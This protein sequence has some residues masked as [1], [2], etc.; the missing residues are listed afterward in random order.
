MK[1]RTRKNTSLMLRAMSVTLV[2]LFCTAAAFMLMGKAYAVMEKQGFGRE[3]SAFHSEYTDYVTVFGKE[4]Y[5]PLKTA[6]D[7]VKGFVAE[8]TPSV[9]KLLG[10][11]VNGTEEL[12]RSLFGV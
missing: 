2:I 11:A 10:K 5:I 12:I 4:Y 6:V 8:H 3:V 1:K 9:I 7:G